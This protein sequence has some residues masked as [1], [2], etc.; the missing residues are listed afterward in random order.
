MKAGPSQLPTAGADRR[1]QGVRQVPTYLVGGVPCGPTQQ[2]GLSCHLDPTGEIR[3]ALLLEAMAGLQS[4][5][6]A[7]RDGGG[8]G[9]RVPRSAEVGDQRLS[10]GGGWG[11]RGGKSGLSSRNRTSDPRIS[12]FDDY[13]PMLYQLSYAE[14]G[15]ESAAASEFPRLGIGIEAT[16]ALY[17]M[18]FLKLRLMCVVLTLIHF[19]L[20]PASGQKRTATFEFQ[21]VQDTS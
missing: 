15:R 3:A 20:Q 19:F 11:G 17:D 16:Y 18:Y 12:A 4:R 7:K 6:D 1:R 13:S 5:A 14:D 2:L 21:D 10:T 8:G 9:A